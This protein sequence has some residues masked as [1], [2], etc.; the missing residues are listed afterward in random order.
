MELLAKQFNRVNV[1]SR[2]HSDK[3]RKLYWA[4]GCLLQARSWYKAYLDLGISS[5]KGFVNN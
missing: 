2:R 4:V 5:C 1:L 3:N